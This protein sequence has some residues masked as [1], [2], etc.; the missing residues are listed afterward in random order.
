M[1]KVA[2]LRLGECDS[3]LGWGQISLFSLCSPVQSRLWLGSHGMKQRG[4]G[5][6]IPVLDYEFNERYLHLI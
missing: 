2:L 4:S 3:W 6:R 1:I 5:Y